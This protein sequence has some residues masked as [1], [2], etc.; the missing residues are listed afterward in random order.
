[1][2]DGFRE[3]ARR[4]AERY[5]GGPLVLV[6]ELVQNARDAGATAVVFEVGEGRSLRCSDDGSGMTEAHARRYLFTLYRS[7]KEGDRGSAGRFGVGF[8]SV[9]RCRPERIVVRSWPERGE[10]WGIALSGD[11]SRAEPVQTSVRAA[12][13]T[14]VVLEFAAPDPALAEAVR[15]AASQDAGL[16]RRRDG[17][18]PLR[19]SVDGADV[20]RPF[21]LPAPSLEFRRRGLRGVVGL[22]EAPLV[23]LYSKGLRVRSAAALRDLLAPAR[24]AREPAGDLPR[25]LAPRVLLDADDLDLVLSRADAR[26]DRALRR[27]VGQA[28]R[29]LAR[30]VEHQ[31]GLMEPGPAW[32]RWLRRGTAPGLAA[33]GGAALGIVLLLAAEQPSVQPV[34]APPPAPGPVVSVA[35]PQ[36]LTDLAAGYRGP[37]ADADRPPSAVALTYEPADPTVRHFAELLVDSLAPDGSFQA[38]AGTMGPY[39]GSPCE[40]DCLDVTLLLDGPGRLPVPTGHALDPEPPRVDPPGRLRLLATRAG[41]PFLEGSGQRVVRYRTG[42]VRSAAPPV[43]ALADRPDAGRLRSIAVPWQSLPGEQRVAEALAFVRRSVI[44]RHDGSVAR[45]HAE[46]A[47]AGIGFVQRTLEVGAGDCDVQNGLLLLLLRTAG[48]PA[49]M[50]IGHLGQAGVAL[51]G[52]HAWLEVHD[53]ASWQVVDASTDRGTVARPPP[54]S[55]PAAP[56]VPEPQRPSAWWL[57]TLAA[58]L[59]LLALARTRRTMH[60]D[61]ALDLAALLRGALQRPE[62]FEAAPAVFHRPL[63]PLLGGGACSLALAWREAERRR[64]FVA[65]RPG[66]LAR[67][68]RRAGAPVLDG[69]RPEAAAVAEALAACD[70][71]AQERQLAGSRGD[72]LTAAVNAHLRRRGES[73]SVRLA[74]VGGPVLVELP[75]R[76]LG[77]APLQILLLDR[78]DARLAEVRGRPPAAARLALLEMALGAL[79]MPAARGVRLLAPLAEAALLEAAR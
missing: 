44:E 5:G 52:L 60:A 57:L 30:L 59:A 34:A 47:G 27:L 23:E 43:Q 26:D 18:G 6:R 55:A 51:P 53:G 39:R 70:L 45:G 25:G 54:V 62:A 3:R 13:G 14:E 56:V 36:A 77:P 11:L 20:T 58:P 41:E 42:P 37:S 49:R 33:L 65:A 31:A 38:P 50:A 35:A 21:S 74:D 68:A 17:R 69:G 1:V 24:S 12:P 29:E 61:P 75:G 10:P 9:L 7:S 67:R 66:R 48:V 4:E 40:R 22:G 46:R 32:R 28:E 71:D 19:V 73:W 16:A 63:L 78:Q 2:T 72:A 76:L 79:E 15:G 8:W 64:L